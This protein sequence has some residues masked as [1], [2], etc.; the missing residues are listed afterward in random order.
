MYAN[1]TSAPEN[2]APPK[3]IFNYSD[4]GK[5]INGLN[6]LG[7]NYPAKIQAISNSLYFGI[8]F[9]QTLRAMDE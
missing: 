9:P 8:E 6:A 1:T 5:P 4:W 7:C 3:I 2:T